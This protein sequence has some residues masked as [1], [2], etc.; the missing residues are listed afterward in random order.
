MSRGTTGTAIRNQKNTKQDAQRAGEPH[1]HGRDPQHDDK[2]RH[3]TTH[4]TG[5]GDPPFH[6]E[7]RTDGADERRPTR[8]TASGDSREVARTRPCGSTTSALR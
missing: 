2:G 4:R 6:R 3:G 7:N 8:A 1:R 5:R